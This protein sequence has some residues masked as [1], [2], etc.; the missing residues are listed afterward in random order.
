MR[1]IV[2]P[3]RLDGNEND[4]ERWN[5]PNLRETVRDFAKK[6]VDTEKKKFLSRQIGG[7]GWLTACVVN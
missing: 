4:R 6:C 1:R 7:C 5:K 3:E 2:K